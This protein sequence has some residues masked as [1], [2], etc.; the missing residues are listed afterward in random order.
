MMTRPVNSLSTREKSLIESLIRLSEINSGSLNSVGVNRV[1]TLLSRWFCQSLNC[2]HQSINLPPYTLFNTDGS[3]NMLP[4]GKLH[5]LRQR[6]EAPLQV[7][8]TGHLDTVFPADSGFQRCQWLDKELLR[9]PGVCDMKG[10]LLVMLEALSAFEKS[11]LAQQVG[12]TVLLNPDEEIGSPG[13]ASILAN[14]AEKHDLGLIYEPALPNGQL[15]GERK[16]SGNF[17]AIIAGVAAHAGREHHLGRNAICAMAEY[18]T[19]LDQLNGQRDGVTI[20][21]GVVDGGVTTNQVPDQ[22]RC[23]FNIRTRIRADE[24]WCQQQLQVL[25]Q[26]INNKEGISLNLHGGFGRSPK[27]LDPAHLALFQLVT[28]CSEEL[29]VPLSWEPTGG[30]CDGNNLSAAGLPNVDTLG[31]L[32]GNIHS[33]REFI[34]L[35][36]LVERARLSTLILL[37]LAEQ[38]EIWRRERMQ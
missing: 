29:G 34:R 32:G 25:G 37:R 33:N 2:Q 18:I 16:G 35:P 23:R 28:E 11:P 26:R 31:V 17:T 27:L 13:S 6:P 24:Q 36:S 22:A 10:G 15:A 8:L 14:E 21:V 19:A 3:R 38:P 12:W 1:G 5:L 7:L 4:L 20:N 30:C 9:G